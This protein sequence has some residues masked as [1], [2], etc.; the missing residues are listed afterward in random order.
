MDNPGENLPRE[1]ACMTS[2]SSATGFC[3]GDPVTPVLA[4]AFIAATA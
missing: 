3:K 4:V 2:R 1:G